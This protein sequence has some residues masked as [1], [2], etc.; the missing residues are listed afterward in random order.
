MHTREG[1]TRAWHPPGSGAAGLLWEVPSCTP[2]SLATTVA[3]WRKGKGRLGGAAL[4]PPEPGWNLPETPVCVTRSLSKTGVAGGHCGVAGD[5]LGVVFGVCISCHVGGHLGGTSPL[6]RSPRWPGPT[7]ASCA[8]HG[9]CSSGLFTAL[10]PWGWHLS[11]CL[12]TPSLFPAWVLCVPGMTPICP[13]CVPCP[14]S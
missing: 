6:Q 4:Q 11:P 2:P 9:M 13:L 7:P 1:S 14:V 5:Q 12:C 10:S 8:G 3:T